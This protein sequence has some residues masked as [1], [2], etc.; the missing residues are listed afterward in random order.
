MQDFLRFGF[1]FV[2]NQLGFEI[3]IRGKQIIS[4]HYTHKL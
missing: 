2:N 1:R 4:T 3:R